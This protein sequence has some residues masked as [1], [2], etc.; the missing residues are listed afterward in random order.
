[1]LDRFVSVF[2]GIN[3]GFIKRNEKIGSFRSN[4]PQLGDAL[5]Q[6]LQDT[7]H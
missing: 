5:E 2:D 1:L 6:V 3:E 4:Q 7:I